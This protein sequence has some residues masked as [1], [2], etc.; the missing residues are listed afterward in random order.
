[1]G[2]HEQQGT[3]R[4]RRADRVG[5][6]APHPPQHVRHDVVV[7][8]V[9][10]HGAQRRRQVDAQPPGPHAEH[11]LGLV[12]GLQRLEQ[13]GLGR[14]CAGLLGQAA[15]LQQQGGGAR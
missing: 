7:G 3:R 11:R 4:P 14:A 9:D 5:N 15:A 2:R 1:V 13:G 8:T 12:A 6:P 10:G